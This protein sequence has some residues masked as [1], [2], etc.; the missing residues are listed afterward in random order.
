MNGKEV[1]DVQDLG[2]N[3]TSDST[4]ATPFELRHVVHEPS[5]P[6]NQAISTPATPSRVNSKPPP[7]ELPPNEPI[8]REGSS[9]QAVHQIDPSE[10]PPNAHVVMPTLVA[11][12]PKAT[13]QN[14]PP[15]PP[16]KD[17]YPMRR[18]IQNDSLDQKVSVLSAVPKDRAE[19]GDDVLMPKSK[20]SALP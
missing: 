8:Q 20:F 3:K 12:Q 1:T 2:P 14:T 16:P 11:R 4:K 7:S 13:R 5:Q 10:L 17:N 9:C 18:T 19:K 15:Q 6:I